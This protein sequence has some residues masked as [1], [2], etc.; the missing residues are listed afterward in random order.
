MLKDIFAEYENGDRQGVMS[1]TPLID[2]VFI[3]LIFFVVTTTFNKETGIPIAKAKAAT[4]SAIEKNLVLIAIDRDGRYWF[5]RRQ[6]SLDE[7]TKCVL[8][9]RKQKTDLSV[10][11]IPDKDGRVEPLVTLMDL[12]RKER[13]TGFSIGT[14][15]PHLQVPAGPSALSDAATFGAIREL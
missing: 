1:M 13:I 2:M 14:Q 3:L 5:D 8:M 6:R 11:L 10:V 15:L 7:I 4:S 9:Q 12:L